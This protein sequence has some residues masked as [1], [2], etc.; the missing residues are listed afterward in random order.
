MGSYFYFNAVRMML[1][2]GNDAAYEIAIFM[3]KQ[4]IL[5]EFS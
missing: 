2:S 4:L 3:G 5:K 1:N